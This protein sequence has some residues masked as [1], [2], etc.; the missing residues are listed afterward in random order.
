MVINRN[1]RN[2]NGRRINGFEKVFNGGNSR[3]HDLQ[4][5]PRGGNNNV[6]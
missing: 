1:A 3:L 2:N 4:V 5:N 6:S